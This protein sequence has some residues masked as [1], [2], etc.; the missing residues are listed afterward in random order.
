MKRVTATRAASI[1]LLGIHAVSTDLI[2]NDPKE[3]SCPRVALPFAFILCCFLNF[4]FFGCNMI[5]FYLLLLTVSCSYFIFCD[6]RVLR[7]HHRLCGHRRLLCA[8]RLFFHRVP[9]VYHHPCLWLLFRSPC[10]FL[11]SE[12]GHAC[13]TLRLCRSRLSHRSCRMTSVL[14]LLRS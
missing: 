11:H 12:K 10:L 2:P 3:S 5:Y 9:R 4:D 13:H 7:D 14:L 1:C 8:L 6:R